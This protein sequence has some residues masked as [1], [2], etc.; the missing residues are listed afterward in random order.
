M[1]RTLVLHGHY[2]VNTNTYCTL[3]QLLPKMTVLLAVILLQIQL[4]SSVGKETFVDNN[5]N[6]QSFQHLSC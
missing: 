4:H 5:L 1:H 3:F 2:L 6:M